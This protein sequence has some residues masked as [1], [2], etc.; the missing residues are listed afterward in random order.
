M[1][2]SGGVFPSIYFLKEA[3]FLFFDVV[4]QTVQNYYVSVSRDMTLQWL[5]E[6]Y[7]LT[8]PCLSEGCCSPTLLLVHTSVFW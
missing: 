8:V 1:P 4:H 7:Y 2:V 6:E 5:I 3:L